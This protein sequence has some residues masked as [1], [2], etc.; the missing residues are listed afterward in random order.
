MHSHAHLLAG[1]ALSLLGSP[2]ALFAARKM[3]KNTFAYGPPLVLW[4]IAGSAVFL[5]VRT[6]SGGLHSLG[7]HSLSFSTIPLGIVATTLLCALFPVISVAQ[8]ALGFSPG[9][10][11][12]FGRI[13]ALPLRS[14]V[15][16]VITA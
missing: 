5:A 4:V 2:L 15:F 11:A 16:M 1:L 6:A 7:L 14:R 8:K 10:P 3:G 12:M 9:D 13:S